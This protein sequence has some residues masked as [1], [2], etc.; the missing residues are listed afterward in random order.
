MNSCTS[1]L[2]IPQPSNWIWYMGHDFPFRT[3]NNI[4]K[5]LFL[6]QIDPLNS[7]LVLML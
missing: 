5:E 2:E 7:V 4:Q 6:E 3:A 1:R